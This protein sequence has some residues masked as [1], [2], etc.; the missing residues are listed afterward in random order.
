MMIAANIIHSA[1]EARCMR[2]LCLGSS[3]IYPREGPRPIPEDALLSGRL[4]STNEAYALAK[5]GALKMAQYYRMQYGC[6]FMSA[7]PCNLYGPG[8]TYDAENSHVIPA[9]IM[10]AHQAKAEGRG[11]LEVWG[12]GKPLREFLYVD[13]LADALVF[14]LQH[15]SDASHI[16]VGA[17][18]EITI[19]ELAGMICDAVGYKGD[20]VFDTS[21]PDGTPSK[22]MDNSRLSQ[23]GWHPRTPLREGIE[24]TYCTVRDKIAS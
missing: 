18:Q 12:S 1:Y 7:M 16:N 10:K 11:S 17:G 24:K 22:M 20:I 21:R 15:Y 6:D 4:E 14:L 5:I 8:D 19:R 2:V 23:M 9:L 13:D 3:C